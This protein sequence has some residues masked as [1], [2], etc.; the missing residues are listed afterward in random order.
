MHNL[1]WNDETAL[2]EHSSNADASAQTTPLV[3]GFWTVCQVQWGNMLSCVW[4]C[5]IKQLDPDTA[6]KMLGSN[7]L[8][9]CYIPE[10]NQHHHYKNLKTHKYNVMNY[11]CN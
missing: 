1:V 4:C 11:E 7:H 3:R 2:N 9:T 6:S 10:Q 5:I 8:V